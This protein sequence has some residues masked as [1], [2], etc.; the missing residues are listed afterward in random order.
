METEAVSSNITGLTNMPWH[1]FEKPG[2]NSTTT[3]STIKL[4]NRKLNMKNLITTKYLIYYKR[5]RPQKTSK[6]FGTHKKHCF[7][8]K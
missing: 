7:K 3:N 8:T 5:N 4:S 6:C 2:M 1:F